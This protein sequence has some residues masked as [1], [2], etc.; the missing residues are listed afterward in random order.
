M[1]RKSSRYRDPRLPDW[2]L[3]IKGS[4][5]C[6]LPLC[7]CFWAP[8]Q[9]GMGKMAFGTGPHGQGLTETAKCLLCPLVPP[10]PMPSEFFPLTQITTDSSHPAE[11]RA[12]ALLPQFPLGIQSLS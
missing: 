2:A 12:P 11:S 8:Q 9:V 4:K 3:A 7:F 6:L 10:F 1:C 5:P